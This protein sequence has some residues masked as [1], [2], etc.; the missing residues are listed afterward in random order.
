MDV[1][2]YA[3]YVNKPRQNIGLKKW[4]WLQIVTSQTAHNKCKWPP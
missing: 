1:E 2:K 4:I 3:Y